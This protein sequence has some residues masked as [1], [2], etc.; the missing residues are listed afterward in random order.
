MNLPPRIT[1][2]GLVTGGSHLD[3]LPVSLLSYREPSLSVGMKSV[4]TEAL[5][6]LGVETCAPLRTQHDKIVHDLCPTAI[7]QARPSL[8]VILASTYRSGMHVSSR[9]PWFASPERVKGHMNNLS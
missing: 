1:L 4:T 7:E 8:R 9:R 3:R 6:S 5:D 2:G